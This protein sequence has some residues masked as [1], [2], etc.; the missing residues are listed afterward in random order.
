L[1][2]IGLDQKEIKNIKEGDLSE[3]IIARMKIMGRENPNPDLL[4]ELEAFNGAMEENP[5]L[6]PHRD[7]ILLYVVWDRIEKGNRGGQCQPLDAVVDDF[8]NRKRT[9]SIRIAR[10]AMAA[11]TIETKQEVAEEA[12]RSS[13]ERAG[14]RR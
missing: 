11:R 13:E 3:T 14:K 5:G 8:W 6:K 12:R 1:E 2:K 7:E 4:L 10:S 9:E